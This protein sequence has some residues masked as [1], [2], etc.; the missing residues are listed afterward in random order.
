MSLISQREI[1]WVNLPSNKFQNELYVLYKLII[2]KSASE[3][4][5]NLEKVYGS[6]KQE[7]G[8][9]RRRRISK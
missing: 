7:G 4:N 6:R 2:S 1:T 8:C 3:I 9:K 5:L